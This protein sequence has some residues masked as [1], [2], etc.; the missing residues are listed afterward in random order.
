M[1]VGETGREINGSVTTL[2]ACLLAYTAS[3]RRRGGHDIQRDEQQA[4]M[5][6][7]LKGDDCI[8]DA[9]MDELRDK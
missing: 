5:M 3:E 7:T 9:H 4:C 6:G 1:L 8:E 2:S